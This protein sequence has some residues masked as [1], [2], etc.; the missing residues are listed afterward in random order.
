MVGQKIMF[1]VYIIDN[2]ACRIHPIQVPGYDIAISYLCNLIDVGLAKLS[3]LIHVA[4]CFWFLI[5]L[6]KGDIIY[7]SEVVPLS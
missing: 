7:V 4:V 2:L 6:V 1:T 5:S 3:L